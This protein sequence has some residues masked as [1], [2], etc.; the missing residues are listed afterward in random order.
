MQAGALEV[1][2]SAGL[3][4]R[5]VIGNS[6]G[7]LNAIQLAADPTVEGTRNM[8]E[9]WRRVNSDHV[10]SISILGGL[11]RLVMQRESLF[12]SHPLARFL[13]ENFPGGV[14][15]FGQLR[16][17]HGIRAYALA[18]CLDTETP[19]LF[20]DDPEDS[21]LDGA[22]AS[23]ALPPYFAPWRV[24]GQYYVDGGVYTNL[25]LRAAI[26]RGATE[27]TALWIKTAIEAHPPDTGMIRVTSAAFTLMVR[28]LSGLELNWVRSQGVPI[29]LIEL[30]PPAGVNFWD[31]G[32]ADRLIE[33]GRRAAEGSLEGEPLRTG[34][35]WWQQLTSAWRRGQ[36]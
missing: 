4:P 13:M 21:L 33:I 2:L 12:P 25:P 24:N 28:N 29:R 7:A 31:F 30:T 16:D 36:A 17:L 32:Q 18:A 19:R 20:G 27:L 8:A 22:M 3:K 9:V 11:Q 26:E 14:Q 35:S 1:L 10:G 15:T 5:V 23:S 6:A 34:Q